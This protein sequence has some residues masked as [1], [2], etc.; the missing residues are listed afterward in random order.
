MKETAVWAGWR[1]GIIARGMTLFQGGQPRP[2]VGPGHS[3][4]KWRL[5]PTWQG[6]QVCIPGGRSR[7]EKT[8]AS[9]IPRPSVPGPLSSHPALTHHWPYSDMDSRHFL[10]VWRIPSWGSEKAITLPQDCLT[11][12]Q[13]HCPPQSGPHCPGDPA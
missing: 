9:A 4:R 2:H 3:D 5:N 12:C 1:E 6:T 10:L 7:V 13:P 11:G 8:E